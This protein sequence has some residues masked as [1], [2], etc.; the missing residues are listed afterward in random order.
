MALITM[1]RVLG[2]GEST[3]SLFLRLGSWG[4]EADGMKRL[5]G[6][7]FDGVERESG[8]GVVEEVVGCN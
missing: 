7:E 6:S 3:I 1:R 8:T 4:N 2:V 5:K